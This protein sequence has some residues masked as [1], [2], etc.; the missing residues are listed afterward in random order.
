MTTPS[1]QG[2]FAQKMRDRY[3]TPERSGS[4][5]ARMR[6]RR[7]VELGR[8]FP[9]LSELRVVDLGG[10]PW[11]WAGAPS[12]PKH[13]T[14][15]NLDADTRDWGPDV[16]Y[17]QADACTPPPAL[18]ATAFDLVYSNSVIEHVGGVWRRREFA[19][20]VHRIAPF[21]W[22]Q[23]PA[24]SFPIEPHWLFPGF[25]FLPTSAQAA[26][27][28]RWPFSAPTLRN[29]TPKEAIEDALSVDLLSATEMRLLFP[30]SE[31]FRERFVGLTKSF[32]AV[33]AP[34]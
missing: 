10:Y 2:S 1:T 31:L 11:A 28:R 23:T 34:A 25:Q 21:H 22:I 26:V 12:R 6:G 14:V 5:T 29:R 19:D 33:R 3:F 18:L 4:L 8:R 24:R 16:T 30:E 9:N 32:A 7:W 27:A 20:V 13:L 17:I 15:V